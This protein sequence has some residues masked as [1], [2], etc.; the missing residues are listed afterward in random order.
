MASLELTKDEILILQDIVVHA[1]WYA[2]EW[3]QEILD[4]VRKKVN[5]AYEKP[6]MQKAEFDKRIEEMRQ[7][8]EN[9]GLAT[10]MMTAKENELN[11]YYDVVTE[12]KDEN[13]GADIR[14]D[15]GSCEHVCRDICYRKVRTGCHGCGADLHSPVLY[16]YGAGGRADHD[17]NRMEKGGES[18]CGGTGKC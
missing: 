12:E 1:P 17:K 5:S 9:K 4:D 18:V 15:S 13:T 8:W 14:L 7:R 3:Q 10:S 2:Y 16:R 6:K 11:F